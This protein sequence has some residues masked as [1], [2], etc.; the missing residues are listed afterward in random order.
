MIEGHFCY[1]HVFYA[2]MA[3][4]G[5]LPAIS[6]ICGA[7]G[8]DNSD[9]PCFLHGCSKVFLSS[10]SWVEEVATTHK[11]KKARKMFPS[12]L[13]FL[14]DRS[15]F[16]IAPLFKYYC[17]SGFQ[18][19]FFP[20]DYNF[21]YVLKQIGF[22]DIDDEGEYSSLM[23]WFTSFW[24]DVPMWIP[25]GPIDNNDISSAIEFHKEY[26]KAVKRNEVVIKNTLIGNSSVCCMDM[27]HETNIFINNTMN[28]IFVADIIG[29][30]KEKERKKAEQAKLN[31]ST[32]PRIIRNKRNSI[33]RNEGENEL[34]SSNVRKKTR[35][36]ESVGKVQQVPDKLIKPKYSKTNEKC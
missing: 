22:N 5:D 34:E 15:L 19:R 8:L 4:C 13:N 14:N 25:P 6:L 26:N 12:S 31:V 28:E 3:L 29:K 7:P 17:N 21:R 11:D 10:V 27:M 20:K 30:E 2:V 36:Y 32:I 18:A 16:Y 23:R 33:E 9:H 1:Y 35:N 24:K